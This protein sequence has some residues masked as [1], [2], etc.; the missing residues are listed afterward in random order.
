MRSG[1]T[2]ARARRT[3][4]H[5]FTLVEIMIVVALIGLLAV[6]AIPGFIRSRATSQANVCIDH[7]RAIDGA[8]Q[9]W[10]LETRRAG[11]EVPVESELQPYLVRSAAAR[12]PVC[13]AGGPT[14]TFASSYDI[15][16]VTNPP[17]CRLSPANHALPL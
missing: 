14:A 7:L 6:I 4:P 16:A 12:M 2:N 11:S 3:G 5:A 8:K 10:A 15:N 17:A 9:Q 13:P 1:S